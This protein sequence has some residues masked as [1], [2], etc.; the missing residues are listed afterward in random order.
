M[1]NIGDKFY[2]DN[3]YKNKAKFCNDNNYRIVIVGEDENGTIY[4]IQDQPQMT[5]EEILQELREQREVECF[6]II[7]Q[8]FI[9]NGQSKTWFDTLT[10][11][12]KVDAEQWVQAWRDVTETKIIPEKPSW[13]K[14]Q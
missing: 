2:F 1:Y 4:Q 11:E 12:Q 10:D 14:Q 8:N 9:I 5:N 7:N 13:L 3:D 6:A